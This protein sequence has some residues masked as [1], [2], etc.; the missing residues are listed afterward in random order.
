MN[1][2]RP[3][4][5]VRP[6]PALGLLLVMLLIGGC[7]GGSPSTPVAAPTPTPATPVSI[8]GQWQVVAHSGVNPASSVLVETNFTQTGATVVA[9]KPSVILIQGAPGE[10]TAL[11]GGW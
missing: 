10:F 11:G 5:R 4:L 1:S 9:D 8:Q 6:E 3:I 2:A 7:G